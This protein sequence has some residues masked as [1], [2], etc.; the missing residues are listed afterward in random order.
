LATKERMNLIS[1]RPPTEAGTPRDTIAALEPRLR[2]L[3]ESIPDGVILVDRD[4][5][6]VYTNGRADRLFGYA[7]GELPGIPIESLMAERF[8]IAYERERAEFL[9]QSGG[10]VS[11][12]RC[13]LYGLRRD[14]SEFPIEVTAGPFET[15]EGTLVVS[16]IRDIGQRKKTERALERSAELT[17]DAFRASDE[18]LQESELRFR[19]LAENIHEVFFLV[20]LQ[21]TRTLYVSPA[22]EQIWGRSC[23]SLYADPNS[24][25]EA[26]HPEDRER[27]LRELRPQGADKAFDVEYRIVRPDGAV[28]SIRSRGYPIRDDAGNIYRI[29]GIAEDV[30]EKRST[31]SELRESERRFKAMLANVDLVAVMLDREARITY[32]NDY[33]LRLTGWSL[34]EVQGRD[35]LELFIRSEAAPLR[36]A[37]AQLLTDDSRSWHN[38]NEIVTRAGEKRLIQWNNTV[39]RSPSGDVVGTASVGKD[40]TLRKRAEQQVRHLNAD[41]ERRVAERTAELQSANLELEAFDYSISHDLR[42]P[43]NRIQGFSAAL[44]EDGGAGLGPQ[45]KDF[46]QRIQGAGREMSHLIDDLLEL[47]LVTR[48]DLERT[49]VDLTAIAHFVFEA[50]AKTQPGRNVEVVVAPGLTARADP[51]LARIVLEN[52]LE[53]AW[54]FTA[55]RP[56]ARIEFLVREIGGE[57]TFMVKDNGAGF[58]AAF[59]ARLFDPFRRQ[60]AQSEFSGTGIGLA[61]VQRI[62]RRHGGRV[63]AEGA[64][65]QGATLYFT[66]SP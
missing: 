14:G 16:A 35:F 31:E 17:L 63:W 62:V 52:L 57:R 6:I 37:F 61:T 64:V 43:L 20:D 41:L 53:N 8:R 26:M 21:H 15:R 29:A 28:R 59:A 49:E 27:A 66:L 33:L 3:L 22:Y 60:H 5:R 4:G 47:S 42:A 48:G 18:E 39:L 13:E 30:T 10:R 24:F 65:G 23:D 56:D 9:T 1:D 7:E 19:Q 54:K 34:E 32:C 55:Q 36:E 38:E 46:V 25:Q 12:K 45:A 51:G 44:L 40:I 11:G 50:L 2:G 58:E